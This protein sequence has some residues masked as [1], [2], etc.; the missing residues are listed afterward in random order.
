M[1]GGGDTLDEGDVREADLP[2]VIAAR[3]R[4]IRLVG[5]GGFASVY[6]AVDERL[7]TKAAVKVLDAQRATS[8]AAL[9]RFRDEALAASRLRHPNIVQVTDY[10]LL[11]DGRP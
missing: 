2:P 3:Y 1:G 4:I 5:R 10:N 9:R 7:H 6:E 11:E 8:Q